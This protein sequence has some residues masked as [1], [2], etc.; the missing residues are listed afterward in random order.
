VEFPYRIKPSLSGGTLNGGILNRM[1][2]FV[3]SWQRSAGQE[4]CRVSH[5][6]G[7]PHE[8]SRLAFVGES[9]VAQF[10]ITVVKR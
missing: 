7:N 4:S 2:H 6:S 9:E 10:P 1:A 8:R 5:F 3:E